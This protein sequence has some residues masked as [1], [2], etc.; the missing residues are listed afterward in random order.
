MGMDDINGV[1]ARNTTEFEDGRPREQATHGHFDGGYSYFMKPKRKPII[2]RTDD[3]YVMPALVE[4]FGKNK[5]MSLRSGS[6][7]TGDYLEDIHR[8][9]QRMD[10]VLL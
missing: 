7:R 10:D 2:R 9:S 3:N 6:A 8:V 4:A 1:F 5:H